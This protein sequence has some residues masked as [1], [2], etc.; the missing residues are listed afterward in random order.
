MKE[1]IN[2]ITFVGFFF[3]V[4]YHNRRQPQPYLKFILIGL[5]AIGVTKGI[6][7]LIKQDAIRYTLVILTLLMGWISYVWLEKK[8]DINKN[9]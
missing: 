7:P 9:S 8:Q 1:A 2:L 4:L 3:L 6:L 5:V